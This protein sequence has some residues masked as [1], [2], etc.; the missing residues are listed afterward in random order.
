MVVFPN[1][2]INLGLFIT[3]KR[4]DGFHS[5][6]TVFLPTPWKEVLEFLPRNS[7]DFSPSETESEKKE[8][9]IFFPTGLPVAG[10]WEDNICYKTLRLLRAKGFDVPP[11]QVYLHKCI[12]MGA[13]L[14]GGSADASF[15]LM[16]L[17]KKFNLNLSE[18]ERSD[19]ALEL[20]SDCPF[21]LYNRPCFASGRGETLTPIPLSLKGMYIQM[22][23]P[24]IHVSTPAAFAQCKPRPASFNLKDLSNLDKSEWKKYV[25]NQ[26]EESVFPAHPALASI[27]AQLYEQ[28]AF[29]ASMSGSGSCIY[30]LFHEMPSPLPSPAWPDH[31]QCFTGKWS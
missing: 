20:G 8:V 30:G 7:T 17:N 2:K 14:G 31:Y 9:D 24:G 12:P 28:G 25:H 1:A 6:E 3:E 10:K 26:F 23:H 13:G 5:L 16:A 27:K 29:Y 15:F 18:Q 21:F 19:I 22:V 11:L 4:K